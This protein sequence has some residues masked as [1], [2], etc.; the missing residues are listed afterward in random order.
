MDIA[1]LL[2]AEASQLIEHLKGRGNHLL[3]TIADADRPLLERSLSRAAVL[4]GE[5]LIDPDDHAAKDE[6][7]SVVN[8]LRFM[9][10]KYAISAAREVREFTQ[11]AIE[12]VAAFVLKAAFAAIP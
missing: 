6:L 8:T 1:T 2:Q 7:K 9:E 11:L 5:L 10:A 12:R 3:S 4:G